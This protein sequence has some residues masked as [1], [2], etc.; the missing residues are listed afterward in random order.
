MNDTDVIDLKLTRAEV[1]LMLYQAMSDVSEDTYCAG[2]IMDNEEMLPKI[3]RVIVALN[4]PFGG[5]G[6]GLV[7]HDTAERLCRMADALGYWMNFNMKADWGDPMSKR[8][9]PYYPQCDR[10]EEAK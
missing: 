1:E 10:K 5:Y 7:S 8:F 6:M 9:V 2:W 4:I 3:C